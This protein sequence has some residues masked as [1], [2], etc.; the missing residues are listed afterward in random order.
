M[1]KLWNYFIILS[2][3]TAPFIFLK[4]DSINFTIFDVLLIMITILSLFKGFNLSGNYKYYYIASLFFLVFSWLSLYNSVDMSTAISTT[5]Q[6]TFV[7]LVLFPTVGKVMDFELYKKVIYI[8]SLVWSMFSIFNLPILNDP[9]FLWGGGAGRFVSFFS[10]PGELG[11]L[12]AIMAPFLIYSLSVKLN[13][14]MTNLFAKMIL[15]V[16]LVSNLSML[17]AS[18]SRSAVIALVVGCALLLIL[19]YGISL[20][21]IIISVV[22]IGLSMVIASNLDLERNALSRLTSGEN[23]STRS[24]DYQLTYDMMREYLFLGTG[25]GASGEAIQYYGGDYRPHNMFLDILIETGVVGLISFSIILAL[26]MFFGIRILWDVIFNKKHTNLLVAA[27]L[28]AGV[29]L[30]VYQQFNTVA[31]HRGYWVIWAF[32]LWLYTQKDYFYIQSAKPREKR[33]R[34][35]IVW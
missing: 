30:L 25:L 35:R 2:F 1:R 33:V 32:C 4:I 34:R 27:T 24:S 10:E 5:L 19:R 6:Y 14:K 22:F 26:C 15:L 18:G 11:A 16:G 8:M 17:I 20:R 13:G 23:I 21:V 29:A 12:T 3:S 31:N 28:S 7:L 9:D